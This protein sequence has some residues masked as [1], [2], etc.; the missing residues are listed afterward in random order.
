MELS[1]VQI[2]IFNNEIIELQR[3][4]HIPGLAGAVISKGNIVWRN[5]LGYS[6]IFNKIKVNPSS[7]FSI[8]SI[9]KTITSTIL[10]SIFTEKGLDID[11]PLSV[12]KINIKNSEQITIRHLLSHTSRGIIGEEFCYSERRFFILQEVLE[13][14]MNQS[15]EQIIMERFINYLNLKNTVPYSYYENPE[16]KEVFKNL[17]KA[18]RF[19]KEL[20]NQDCRYSNFFSVTD[21]LI[22]SLE[23][24]ITY[25]KALDSNVIISN[26]IKNLAW[27]GKSN[28]GNP[29]PYG[30][31]WFI[32]WFQGNKLVW[33]YGVSNGFSSV[34]LK[35]PKM[36]LSFLLLT[37]NE[38][39]TN[40]FHFE[41]CDITRSPFITVFL[42]SFLNEK[43][44]LSITEVDW[45]KNQDSLEDYLKQ[46]ILQLSDSNDI[47][48]FM[49]YIES[50]KNLYEYLGNYT[51][52]EKLN[53]II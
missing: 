9:T 27:S 39:L 28:S 21:G 10:L 1:S 13:K 37:N 33:H 22:S 16:Y 14:V 51:V 26:E 45:N 6:D 12:F 11:I 15:I 32:Q 5:Y 47:E 38:E 53:H 20:D 41:K 46:Q 35:L 3:K 7:I 40:A 43:S 44:T 19:S 42:K 36:E 4:L 34:I 24:M 52:L 31:G 50:Y 23:D 48:L 18:Y 49:K 30:L 2:R 25:S 8:A 17:A 29:L